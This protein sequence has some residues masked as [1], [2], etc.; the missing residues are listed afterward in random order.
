[1]SDRLEGKTALITGAAHG[2]GRAH[3]VRFAREGADVVV[4]DLA[5][6]SAVDVAYDLGTEEELEETA[7]MVEREDRRA[8]WAPADIRDRAALQA[9]FDATAD[10]FPELDIIVANAGITGHGRI[11]EVTP[12][13]WAQHVDINLTGAFNTI[14]T[15]LPRMIAGGRGGSIV[16][17]SSVAGIK[18]LPFFAAYSAA[19]H[20][21]QGLMA[22]LAQELA[23]H[24][25]RVN[26][27]NPGPIG[28]PMTQNDSILSLFTD[29]QTMQIFQG[30]FAPMLPLGAEGWMEPE[31]VTEAVLWLA[32]DGSRN[33][34]GLAVPVDA[35]VMVR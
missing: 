30:S 32:S 7:R 14:Q 4:T 25:I 18:G 6:P 8:F 16:I 15:F 35:G 3:A 27:V 2:Q 21:L 12:E 1:M 9:V 34:T 17:T 19:K 28:T 33:V 22:V 5:D 13:Q 31:E 26:T 11:L 20:G 10:D 29:E 23:E 24:G